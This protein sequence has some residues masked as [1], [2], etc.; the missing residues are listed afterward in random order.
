MCSSIVCKQQMNRLFVYQKK[1][2]DVDLILDFDVLWLCIPT[3]VLGTGYARTG[4]YM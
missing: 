2:L 1:T 4:V 3:S